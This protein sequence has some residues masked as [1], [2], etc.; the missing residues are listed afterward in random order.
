VDSPRAE[1]ANLAATLRQLR[2]DAGLSQMEAAAATG[3]TQVKI[4]R[5]ETGK[6]TP[7]PDDVDRVTRAYK[8]PAKVRRALE[9]T[10]RDLTEGQVYSRIIL[11]RGAWQMQQ[12]TGRIE[13]ESGRVRVFHP[14]IVP[15]LLQTPAYARAMFA[16][17]GIADGELERTVRARMARQELLGSNREFVLLM[18]EGALRWQIGSPQLMLDL[19][20]HIAATIGLPNVRVGIIPYSTRAT[21]FVQEGFDLYDTRAVIIGTT[22]ATATITDTRDLA[23]YDKLFTELEASASI[24]DA[25]GTELERI[26]ADYRALR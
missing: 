26:A 6:Y 8:A 7:Q 16:S 12:M 9:R 4:S 15:G 14:T 10:A 21:V 19:I 2:K 13:A 5:L 25:A 3:L 23:I 17:V 11:Q 18:S 22:T 20:D 1:H 24:G